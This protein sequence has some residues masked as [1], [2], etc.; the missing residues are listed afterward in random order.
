MCL[1]FLQSTRVVDT[2][3][4]AGICIREVLGS[5]PGRNNL[6]PGRFIVVPP[7]T[8]FY[9]ARFLPYCHDLGVTIDGVWIGE[10]DLL[11]T[12]TVATRNYSQLQ[13]YR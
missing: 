4:A 12:Y 1:I 13:H 2:T 3:A 8:R 11:A 6:Y 10:W 5:D 7:V 9:L